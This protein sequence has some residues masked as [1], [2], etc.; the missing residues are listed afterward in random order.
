MKHNYLLYGILFSTIIF[1]SSLINLINNMTGSLFIKNS[2]IELK[3]LKDKNDYLVNQYNSLLDFKN[4]I[5]MKYDYTITNVIKTN[6]GFGSLQIT[7][8][9]YN[10]GSEVVNE[11]GLV[12]IISKINGS[13]SNI[14]YLYDTNLVV[15]INEES[16]KIS[17]KDSNNNLIIKEIS[18]YNNIKINDLV[19]SINGTYIGKIIK[20][21][22]DILDNY[23]TV[24]TVKLDNINYV[25][26]INR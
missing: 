8:T 9:N 3:L 13:N 22:Y 1:R 26:V 4:N 23:L 14:K 18:N 25:A 19:Y 7:G 21:K 5:D 17:D 12:G 16:G 2:S 11:E 6:Y 24:K 10:I 20:I 15:K